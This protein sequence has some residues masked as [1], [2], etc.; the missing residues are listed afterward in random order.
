M[1]LVGWRKLEDSEPALEGLPKLSVLVAGKL[2]SCEVPPG[3][4]GST[5]DSIWLEG[6]LFRSSRGDVMFLFP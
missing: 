1:I 2:G 3:F 6:V 5:D 4:L